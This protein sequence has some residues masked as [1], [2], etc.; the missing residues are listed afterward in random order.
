MPKSS[1]HPKSAD[2]TAQPSARF[3]YGAAMNSINNLLLLLLLL[4]DG[5][6]CSAC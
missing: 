6:R 2:T 5:E 4:G 3:A 1:E